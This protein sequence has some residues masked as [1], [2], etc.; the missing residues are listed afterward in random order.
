[1]RRFNPGLDYTIPSGLAVL[2]AGKCAMG[3]CNGSGARLSDQPASYAVGSGRFRETAGEFR[4]RRFQNHADSG[5]KGL[6]DAAQHAQ[7]MYLIAAH[8]LPP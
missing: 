7:G 2:Y 6:G 5:I 4:C 3:G 1:M 8:A